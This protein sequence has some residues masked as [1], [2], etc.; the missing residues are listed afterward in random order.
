MARVNFIQLRRELAA[1]EAAVIK[2]RMKT[3]LEEKFKEEK[4][5]LLKAFDE[6]NVTQELNA[7]PDAQSSKFISTKNGG[8]L[9]S[10]LGFAK[11]VTP[12]QDLRYDLENGISK[13]QVVKIPSGKS[14][15]L[16]NLE[17]RIPTLGELKRRTQLLKWTTRSFIDVIENGIGNFRRYMFDNDRFKSISRSGTGIQIKHD[18]KDRKDIGPIEYISKLIKD[19][20]QNLRNFN[21]KTR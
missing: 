13:G 17:V 14:K 15:F 4:A 6:H 3:I 18:I 5:A 16:Y 11:G 1:Q 2:P 19:F 8:N 10:L 7:G 12:A 9:Y 20:Q 21:R